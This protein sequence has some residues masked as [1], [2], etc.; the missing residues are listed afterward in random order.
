MSPSYH[1]YRLLLFTVVLALASCSSGL[2]TAESDARVPDQVRVDFRMSS[3]AAS[4]DDVDGYDKDNYDPGTGTPFENFIDVE[5]ADG[6]RIYF[7]DDDNLRLIQELTLPKVT[8]TDIVEGGGHSKHYS[9]KGSV[10]GLSRYRDF[11]VVVLANWPSYP[12]VKPGV[13]TIDDI[14][15]DAYSLFG[16]SDGNDFPVSADN[17]IPLYGVK[18]C[19][20][21]EMVNFSVTSLGTVHLLRAVAKI[22]VNVPADSRYTIKSAVVYNYNHTGYCAPEGVYEESDYIHWNYPDDYVHRLHLVED[23]NALPGASVVMR[24]VDDRNFIAYLPEYDN[25]TGVSPHVSIGV[26]LNEYIDK[27]YRFEAKMYDREGEPYMDLERNNLYRFTIKAVNPPTS[28]LDV[29]LDLFPYKIYDL[30]PGF[31]Q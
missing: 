30:S 20:G 19:T 31:G 8:V 23:G 15:N 16:L 10:D 12:A 21:V 4:A 28:E 17:P 11:R 6:Y 2:D 25:T 22:H 3:L 13:T 29:S 9:V 18:R 24:R 14:V 26:K 5:S 27:E 1:I 7:F